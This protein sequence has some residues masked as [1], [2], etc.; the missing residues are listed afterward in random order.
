MQPCRTGRVRPCNLKTLLSATSDCASGRVRCPHPSPEPAI[1]NF[2]CR[3]RRQ[4]SVFEWIRAERQA[5]QAISGMLLRL[6]PGP[7]MRPQVRCVRCGSRTQLSSVVVTRSIGSDRVANC[8]F[9]GPNQPRENHQRCR[10]AI[11]IT[12]ASGLPSHPR[13]PQTRSSLLDHSLLIE[14]RRHS[15]AGCGSHTVRIALAAASSVLGVIAT[16]SR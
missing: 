15:I 10:Q 14:S 6:H 9:V 1:A 3:K 5:T 2:R 7:T 4:G 16:T 8:E 13:R 12:T 11:A